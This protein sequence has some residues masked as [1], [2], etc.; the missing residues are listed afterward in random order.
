MTAV[1]FHP[2][3]SIMEGV[4]SGVS[5]TDVLVLRNISLGS[6]HPPLSGVVQLTQKRGEGRRAGAVPTED[7]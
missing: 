3:F 2:Y 4:S 7:P 5:S 6:R 1:Y